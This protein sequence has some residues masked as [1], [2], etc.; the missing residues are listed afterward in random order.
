M[1]VG[2]SG[3]LQ[4]PLSCLHAPRWLRVQQ[5][6]W[7]GMVR[8]DAERSGPCVE[9]QV[10][11]SFLNCQTHVY[12]GTKRAA[13]KVVMAQE[14]GSVV[15]RESPSV[16]ACVRACV[17]VGVPLPCPCFAGVLTWVREGAGRALS[18]RDRVLL[19]RQ[20][21]WASL[22]KAVPPTTTAEA[23]KLAR[24]GSGTLG[25]L[26]TSTEGP[27][28]RGRHRVPSDRRVLTVVKVQAGTRPPGGAI[29]SAGPSWPALFLPPGRRLLGKAFRSPGRRIAPGPPSQAQEGCLALCS[30]TSA[31][32]SLPGLRLPLGGTFPARCSE[33]S[34]AFLWSNS[35]CVFCGL[36]GDVLSRGSGRFSQERGT[37]IFPKP[38]PPPSHPLRGPPF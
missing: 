11:L 5:G 26:V 4:G 20:D 10:S 1:E 30:Y 9:F 13:F 32:C 12:S 25:R 16:G 23:W 21:S 15:I 7:S 18:H 6:P 35:G 37:G 14:P 28:G 38:S 36:T 22:G 3:K 17:C 27:G 8:P 24:E 29:C 31:S 33:G 34:D 2:C 19:A